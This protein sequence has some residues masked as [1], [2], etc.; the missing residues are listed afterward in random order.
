[1]GGTSPSDE[2]PYRTVQKI[3]ESTGGAYEKRG[4]FFVRVTVAP[5][6]RQAEHVP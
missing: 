6:K 5:Q 4:Q 2:K 1:M 3:R